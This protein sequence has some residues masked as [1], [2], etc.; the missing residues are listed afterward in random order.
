VIGIL[1]DWFD[2]DEEEKINAQLVHSRRMVPITRSQIA[3]AM[4]GLNLPRYGVPQF[5]TACW[6]SGVESTVFIAGRFIHAAQRRFS[7][8]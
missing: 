4:G 2:T 7:L 5:L 1:H 3:F 6:F 8:T